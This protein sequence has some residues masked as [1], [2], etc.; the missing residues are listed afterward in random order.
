MPAE[1]RHA[2]HHRA[3]EPTVEIVDDLT[4]RGP[5]GLDDAS[6]PASGRCWVIRWTVATVVPDSAQRAS[7][8]ALSTLGGDI[9]NEVMRTPVAALMA[10]PIVAIGGTMPVS[11]TPRRHRD[12]TG[13]EPRR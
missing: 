6:P 12:A 3:R 5:V 11:P 7:P 13:S 10:L 4:D 1:E 8:S 2:A 9:G